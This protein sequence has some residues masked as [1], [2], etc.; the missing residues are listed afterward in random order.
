MTQITIIDY[1]FE[2]SLR[3]RVNN[4]TKGIVPHL[5]GNGE[6]LITIHVICVEWEGELCTFSQADSD[7]L[8]CHFRFSHGV[9]ISLT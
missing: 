6:P 7:F 1:I 5:N 3:Q 8:R 9:Q 2:S 4:F